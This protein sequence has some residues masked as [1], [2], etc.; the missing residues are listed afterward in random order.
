LSTCRL[1]EIHLKKIQKIERE[2]KKK[3]AWEWEWEMEPGQVASRFSCEA[4]GGGSNPTSY[5]L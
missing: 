3:A 1:I 4:V 2:K 5:Q